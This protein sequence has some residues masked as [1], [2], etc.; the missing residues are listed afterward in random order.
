MNSPLSPMSPSKRL[1]FNSPVQHRPRWGWEG[2]ATRREAKKVFYDSVVRTAASGEAVTFRVGDE[3][4]IT[5]P[6]TDIPYVARIEALFEEG[7]GD[8]MCLLKWYYR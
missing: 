1:W 5:A 8:M 4:F 2:E 6:D 3:A 7:R